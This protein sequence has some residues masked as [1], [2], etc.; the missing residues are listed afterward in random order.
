M[1]KALF[2]LTAA[3][4]CCRLI[5]TAACLINTTIV[6]CIQI[7]RK[8]VCVCDKRT[9]WVSAVSRKRLWPLKSAT[10]D[11][12]SCACIQHPTAWK[13]QRGQGH[14]KPTDDTSPPSISNEVWI[15]RPVCP[16]VLF[17]RQEF[18]RLLSSEEMRWILFLS[19]DPN[20]PPQCM[21]LHSKCTQRSPGL[22]Q[23]YYYNYSPEGLSLKE[24]K[25]SHN[26]LLSFKHVFWPWLS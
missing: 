9:C 26:I 1:F 14:H 25:F 20:I 22:M 6:C 16:P 8:C 23:Q 11:T 5:L 17:P 24:S 13:K 10:A 4:T 7:E 21:F 19:V 3:F 12:S 15:V 2:S 18:C